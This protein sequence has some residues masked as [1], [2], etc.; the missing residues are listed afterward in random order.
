MSPSIDRSK[1]ETAI[2]YDDYYQL[3]LDLFEEGKTTGADQSESLLEYAGL[4]LQRMKRIQ[5]T[6]QL[7]DESKKALKNKRFNMIWL[8]LT[9]GWCGDAA[10]NLPIMNSI[11]KHAEGIELKTILRDEHLDLMDQFLT[12]GGRSIPKLIALDKDSLEVLFTWGPRPAYA[13]Q[14]LAEFKKDEKK[15]YNQFAKEMQL[16]YAKDKGGS[17]EKE[18]ISLLM[19]NS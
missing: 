6:F 18:L 9:E 17:T 10:Q 5:K 19:Q 1:V 12:N 4:N 3:L 14:M 11:A 15:A 2:S 8:V 16:W 7:S 13:Q